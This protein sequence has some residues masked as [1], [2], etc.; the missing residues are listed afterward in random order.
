MSSRLLIF[1]CYQPNGTR[2]QAMYCKSKHQQREPLASQL[3]K[4]RSKLNNRYPIIH[5]QLMVRLVW[6]PLELYPSSVRSDEI[7]VLSEDEPL[8]RR[9]G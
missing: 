2:I 1:D 3:I 8:H 6:H 7:D 9:H 4:M 5:Q